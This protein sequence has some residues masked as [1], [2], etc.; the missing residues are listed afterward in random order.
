MNNEDKGRANIGVDL[1]RLI[2]SLLD[3]IKPLSKRATKRW[4][5]IFATAVL[6]LNACGSNQQPPLQAEPIKI[7]I[8]HPW[9]PSYIFKTVGDWALLDSGESVQIESTK[10]AAVIGKTAL[11]I[12]N[13]RIERDTTIWGE[14]RVN[15]PS[16]GGVVA[17]LDR[18]IGLI[19][20]ESTCARTYAICPTWN[21]MRFGKKCSTFTV[22]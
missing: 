10:W 5:A 17:I 16:P 1:R 19:C 4:S 3:V 12:P 15:I 21:E 20:V 9:P 18:K 22:K 14:K 6:S 11:P 7:A 2:F 13:S 8:Y